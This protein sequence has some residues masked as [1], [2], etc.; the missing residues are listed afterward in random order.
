[1]LSI[2][3]WQ[4]RIWFRGIEVPFGCLSLGHSQ[5][6][7]RDVSGDAVLDTTCHGACMI[8]SSPSV[9]CCSNV[10]QALLCLQRPTNGQFHSPS[11]C[12]KAYLDM[13]F[14]K[15]EV[16]YFSKTKHSLLYISVV[17]LVIA[18]LPQISLL[19]VKAFV[20]FDAELRRKQRQSWFAALCWWTWWAMISQSNGSGLE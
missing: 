8:V 6:H 1:M 2:S 5:K 17:D 9:Y 14:L 3:S 10:Y 13:I 4:V 7:L 18:R 15:S 19:D 16:S 20:T 12:R 11:P